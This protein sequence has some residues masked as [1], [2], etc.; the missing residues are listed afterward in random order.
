MKHKSRTLGWFGVA[1]AAYWLY[2]DYQGKLKEA[3][4]WG[5]ATLALIA[6]HIATAKR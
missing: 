6:A 1:A 5:W 2:A 4:L 3:V